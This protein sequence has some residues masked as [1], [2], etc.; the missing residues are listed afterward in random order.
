MMSLCPFTISLRP[1][2][3]IPVST[4]KPHSRGLPTLVQFVIHYFL[5][6]FFCILHL[7]TCNFAITAIEL[8]PNSLKHLFPC[9]WKS[10]AICMF[11]ERTPIRHGSHSI[12]DIYWAQTT[13]E[14]SQ[15]PLNI[16]CETDEQMPSVTNH[17]V[18]LT[19]NNLQKWPET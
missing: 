4:A 6:A 3:C 12:R 14:P 1:D 7:H 17:S 13:T 11:N 10:L 15:T 2:N 5:R 18:R 9:A 8:H 16:S 19:T